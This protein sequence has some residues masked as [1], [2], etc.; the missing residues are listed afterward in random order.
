M[1]K[2]I[3]KEGIFF[4]RIVG[5]EFLKKM[6]VDFPMWEIVS[7][8]GNPEVLMTKLSNLIGEIIDEFPF[9][10]VDH[11]SGSP[12]W[13][14]IKNDSWIPLVRPNGDSEFSLIDGLKAI[15]V[16]ERPHTLIGITSFD[17]NSIVR[18]MEDRSIGMVLAPN[19]DRTEWFF[20]FNPDSPVLMRH[21]SFRKSYLFDTYP[22]FIEFVG[23]WF[24]GLYVD[25]FADM[26][27][28]AFFVTCEP[29]LEVRTKISDQAYRLLTENPFPFKELGSIVNRSFEIPENASKWVKEILNGFETH[30]RYEG[31]EDRLLLILKAVIRKYETELNDKK[32]TASDPEVVKRKMFEPYESEYGAFLSDEKGNRIAEFSGTLCVNGEFKR[33][34]EIGSEF[35]NKFRSSV[36]A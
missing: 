12:D 4:R 19:D 16:S 27:E 29:A 35:E 17:K 32:I 14:K 13:K 36:E 5:D 28:A 10:F 11:A 26:K 2:F 22:D 30:I 8:D 9:M 15:Y 3:D 20:A 7:P 23:K 18:L 1:I 24:E 33:E 6:A 31:V 25:G 21:A 34:S